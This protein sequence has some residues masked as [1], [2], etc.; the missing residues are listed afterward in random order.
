MLWT[1]YTAL[2]KDRHGFI[3]KVQVVW[4][5][6]SLPFTMC[7]GGPITCFMDITWHKHI[8]ALV[9]LQRSFTIA[10]ILSFNEEFD[11]KEEWG[12]VEVGGERHQSPSCF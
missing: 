6:N 5:S 2:L 10:S 7:D 9:Y 8:Y 11:A 1:I 4:I 12:L 3:L